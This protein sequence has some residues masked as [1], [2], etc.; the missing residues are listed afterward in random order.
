LR[1]LTGSG[2][3]S[4]ETRFESSVCVGSL[5]FHRAAVRSAVWELQHQI[6]LWKAS[7]SATVQVG[8]GQILLQKSVETGLEA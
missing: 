7:R 4:L 5:F 6:D 2:R 1:S 8:Y 3:L